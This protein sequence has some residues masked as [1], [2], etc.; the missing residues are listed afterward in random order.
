MC[1]CYVLEFIIVV[2]RSKENMFS[3]ALKPCCDKKIKFNF[4]TIPDD[5]D[6]GTAESLKF[7]KD[8]IEV[9]KVFYSV[10]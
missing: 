5:E 3:Q 10:N 4:V 7:I 6:L 2:L 1:S 9:S 8:K